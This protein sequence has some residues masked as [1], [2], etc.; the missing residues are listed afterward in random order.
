MN[1]LLA[2]VDVKLTFGNDNMIFESTLEI[3]G[4]DGDIWA[5]LGNTD[6]SNEVPYDVMEK[7]IE[8]CK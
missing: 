1:K 6:I 7:I 3:Y 2:Q 8:D 4:D 5:I